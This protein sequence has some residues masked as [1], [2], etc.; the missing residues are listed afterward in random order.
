LIIPEVGPD[1]GA[2]GEHDFKIKTYV[3]EASLG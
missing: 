2:L 3:K 1:K